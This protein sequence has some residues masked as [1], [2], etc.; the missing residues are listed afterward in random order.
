MPGTLGKWDK[1]TM[2]N[3]TVKEE[4]Q[5]TGFSCRV[6]WLLIAVGQMEKK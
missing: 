5:A 6:G 2:Y 3:L 4:Q 1:V